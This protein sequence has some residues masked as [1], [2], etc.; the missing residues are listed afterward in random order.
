M[1]TATSEWIQALEMQTHDFI[2]KA[3]HL[4]TLSENDV[5]KRPSPGSWNALECIEHLNRYGVFYLPEIKKRMLES[6]FPPTE[7]FKP[8][9]LGSY[10][11]KSMLPKEGSKKI[12]TF[13]DKDPIHTNLDKKC[14]Y[15]FIAQQK[16]MLDLLGKARNVDLNR[17]KTSLSITKLL[18]LKLGDTFRFLVN[19][20]ERHMVQAFAALPLRQKVMG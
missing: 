2:S 9:V 5:R 8:G 4:L 10:F 16:E 20:N 7:S 17:T 13:K 14:I 6:P 3:E 15:T 18:T 19:H 11:A 1:R 12:K